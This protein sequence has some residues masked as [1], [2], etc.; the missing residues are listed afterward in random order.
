M[1]RNRWYDKSFAST[2]QS[3]AL[4]N[5]GGDLLAQMRRVAHERDPTSTGEIHHQALTSRGVPREPDETQ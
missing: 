2:F 1:A 5:V 3:L 4:G